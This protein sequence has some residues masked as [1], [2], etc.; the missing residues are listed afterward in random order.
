M[1]DYNHT[2]GYVPS[3]AR[4]SRAENRVELADET[5][6]Y[7]LR[8]PRVTFAY[9]DNDRRLQR[10]CAALHA[11]RCWKPPAAATSGR[12]ATPAT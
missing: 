7:G 6:Q 8:I 11:A 9:S 10:P 2:A 12:D 3:S 1:L 5:D 4:S